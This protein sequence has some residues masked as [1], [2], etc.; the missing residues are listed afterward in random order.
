MPMCFTPTNFLFL[1]LLTCC[2]STNK[3]N[4]VGDQDPANVSLEMR[5][6]LGLSGDAI[7]YSADSTEQV[8]QLKWKEI[9]MSEYGPAYVFIDKRGKDVFIRLIEIPDFDFEKNDYFDVIYSDE[10]VFPAVT[11]RQEG[12]D[13]WYTVTIKKEMRELDGAEAEFSI[14][15]AIARTKE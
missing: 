2:C 15:T 13:R 11:L 5:D 14:I 4:P 1:A 6:T 10:S 9:N 3:K 8:V 12:I 7:G